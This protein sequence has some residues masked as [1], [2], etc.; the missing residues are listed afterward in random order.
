[1][2]LSSLTFWLRIG[3]IDGVEMLFWSGI[4]HGVCGARLR[5]ALIRSKS[6]YVMFVYFGINIFFLFCFVWDM[7]G[8]KI[9]NKL[10]QDAL[11]ANSASF[12][13]WVDIPPV[14]L[15]LLRLCKRSAARKDSCSSLSRLDRLTLEMLK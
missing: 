2:V 8:L 6:R 13:E 4:L 15:R 12:R 5:F 3:A 1:M 11:T 10:I 9:F 7:R 14:L